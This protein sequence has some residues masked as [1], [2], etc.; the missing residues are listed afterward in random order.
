[1]MSLIITSADLL[2]NR[3]ERFAR[4]YAERNIILLNVLGKWTGRNS[5]I[6]MV[7]YHLTSQ[8]ACDDDSKA[9]VDYAK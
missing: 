9:T 7:N 2:L 5:G 4:N 8:V 6:C 3:L 1:M